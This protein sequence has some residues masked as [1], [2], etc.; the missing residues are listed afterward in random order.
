MDFHH[1]VRE[2]LRSVPGC[3][4]ILPP[5][6]RLYRDAYDAVYVLELFAGTA[7]RYG[8][9]SSHQLPFNI[10]HQENR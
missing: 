5:G 8:L 9:R 6:C 7:N 10:P 1:R 2:I 4:S 3:N